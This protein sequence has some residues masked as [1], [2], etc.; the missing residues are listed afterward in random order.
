LRPLWWTGNEASSSKVYSYF[1]TTDN[2]KIL[3]LTMIIGIQL[4]RFVAAFFV[5]LTHSLGE[6]E[7]LKPFGSF[8]VDIFFVISGFIIYVITDKDAKYFFIKRLIR[9]VP[10]YWLFTFGI[11]FIAFLHPDLLRSA[12]FDIH[13]II[14]SLFFFPYWTEGTA[15]SPILKLGWTL[16]FEMFFYLMFFVS[17]Q[18]SHKYRAILTSVI[19]AFIVILL[20]SIESYSEKS[21]LNFYSSLIWFE[22][23]FGMLIG[24]LYKDYNCLKLNISSSVIFIFLSIGFMMSIQIFGDSSYARIFEFGLP[25]SLLIIASLNFESILIRAH[26]SIKEIILFLGEMSYPLYL[27]HIYCIALL[28]RV[29]FREI[30]FWILF[31]AAFLFSLLIS[32]GISRYYD[33]PLRNWLRSNLVIQLNG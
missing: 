27:I 31:P 28:H 4:L 25:S 26:R 7:W 3:D 17:M 8:G 20:N 13:H 11:S 30:E 29:L 23:I 18:L 22:F 10:M 9:I 33:K 19:L 15:F 5:V 32:Y 24:V 16:N 1:P 2:L 21:F 12:K 6:Y 14:A